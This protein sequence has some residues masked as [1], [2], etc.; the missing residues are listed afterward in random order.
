MAELKLEYVLGEQFNVK[1]LNR[2]RRVGADTRSDKKTE[3]DTRPQVRINFEVP[4]ATPL[5]DMLVGSAVQKF[6][7]LNFLRYAVGVITAKDL[8][9]YNGK[10]EAQL[11]DEELLALDGQT[12]LIDEALMGAYIEKWETESPKTASVPSEFAT[13]SKILLAKAAKAGY[14][15]AADEFKAAWVKAVEAGEQ[16]CNEKIK[17]GVLRMLAQ[18][19]GE[20][21]DD[22]F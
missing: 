9:C 8:A 14:K 5:E 6:W 18:V 13:V 17:A 7:D 3:D 15:P 12:I 21:E 2:S 22:I 16:D 11:T 10:T 4:R 1:V 20:G 19:R